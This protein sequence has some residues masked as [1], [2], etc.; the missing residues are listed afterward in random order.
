MIRFRFTEDERRYM[1][2]LTESYRLIAQ[3]MPPAIASQVL[4]SFGKL[5]Q[6]AH[7]EGVRQGVAIAAVSNA[8]TLAAQGDL[9]HLKAFQ[10]HAHV[11]GSND[12]PL[13]DVET[14][15]MSK[16]GVDVD[17]AANGWM[18]DAPMQFA[19]QTLAEWQEQERLEKG[20]VVLSADRAAD[21]APAQPGPTKDFDWE[22][23]PV[24][25]EWMESGEDYDGKLV[26]DYFPG[27]WAEWAVHSKESGHT[28][29]DSDDEFA[30]S[31]RECEFDTLDAAL[32][33]EFS[34]ESRTEAEDEPG[35]M[36]AFIDALRNPLG[37]I[38][39]DGIDN[40]QDLIMKLHLATGHD[41]GILDIQLST[42]VGRGLLDQCGLFDLH[43]G[44]G[45]NMTA[46][47]SHREMQN[48]LSGAGAVP[49]S[50]AEEGNGDGAEPNAEGPAR[51]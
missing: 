48:R 37:A 46:F 6:M 30:I 8:G 5:E 23:D 26:E 49:V 21:V 3:H 43:P 39:K 35:E 40:W 13:R 2:L 32:D 12:T 14:K 24:L 15:W 29:F 9:E 17:H 4:R 41:A 27:V 10:L 19:P 28:N 25:P 47:L 38:A 42:P 33:E 22:P 18:D 7:L 16:L 51:E 36:P 20:D 11:Y 31:C 50:G 45:L 44:L 34:A 1:L